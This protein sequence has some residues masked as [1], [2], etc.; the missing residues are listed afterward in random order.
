MITQV[1]RL[2]LSKSVCTFKTHLK[3]VWF[4]STEIEPHLFHDEII[5]KTN[6]FSATSSI[7]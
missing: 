3:R 1:P 5:L 6:D 2:V 4:V 7:G